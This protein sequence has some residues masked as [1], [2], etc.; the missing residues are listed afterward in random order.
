MLAYARLI[1][2]Y[3]WDI[4]RGLLNRPVEVW[5]VVLIVLLM[6]GSTLVI[7]GPFEILEMI[8]L[9]SAFLED[10]LVSLLI[11]SLEFLECILD[12]GIATTFHAF[13]TF[14]EMLQEVRISRSCLE[15]NA[16]IELS[17]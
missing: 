16:A 7:I 14:W 11:A 8:H 1:L 9:C 3:F 10:V 17:T 5:I 15:A 12:V 13:K 4:V 6:Y 2:D